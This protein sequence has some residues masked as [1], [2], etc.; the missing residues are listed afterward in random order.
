MVKICYGHDAT[1]EE[2]LPFLLASGI[3]T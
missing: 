1:A 3:E 2:G